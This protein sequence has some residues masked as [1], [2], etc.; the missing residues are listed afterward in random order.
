MLDK[1]TDHRSLALLFVL[2]TPLL[3]A[4]RAAFPGV[5]DRF[6]PIL[7]MVGGLAAG[8]AHALISGASLDDA[9]FSAAIGLSGGGTA[10][11]VHQSLKKKPPEGPGGGDA[12][13]PTLPPPAKPKGPPGELARV[14]WALGLLF[15]FVAISFCQAACTPGERKTAADVTKA[16]VPICEE[17]LVLAAAPELAP[18]CAALPE[19]EA[20]IAELVAEHGSAHGSTV[21]G[22]GMRTAAPW[23]PS[24][25]D[26]HRKLAAKKARAL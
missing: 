21:A 1:L 18:M 23:R 2:M 26:V 10:V 9:V 16:A 24:M 5:P 4:L 6:I 15:A 20:A 19:I 8:V 22:V 14:A 11:A 3:S 25:A 7:S 13:A 17:G 12:D